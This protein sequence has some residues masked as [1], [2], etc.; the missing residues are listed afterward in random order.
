MKKTLIKPMLSLPAAH[1]EL[2]PTEK[3]PVT[4]PERITEPIPPIRPF[5]TGHI[6]LPPST[7]MAYKPA[8]IDGH[9]RI[10]PTPAL[11]HFKEEAA[12]WLAWENCSFVDMPVLEALRASRHIKTPLRVRLTPWFSSPWKRDLDGIYKFSIDAVFTY[13]QLNDNQIVLVDPVEKRVDAEKPRVG[14][15]LWCLT[16]WSF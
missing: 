16:Q 2:L 13:L 11:E 3:F 7:N 15:E 8:V 9:L 14:V 12:Q 10:I 5:F 1:P 4:V 6:P